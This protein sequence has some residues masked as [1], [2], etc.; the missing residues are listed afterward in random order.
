M[1]EDTFVDIYLRIGDKIYKD[2][3]DEKINESPES[4]DYVIIDS[5]NEDNMDLYNKREY[6]LKDKVVTFDSS[7]FI[8]KILE[9][10]H[11]KKE[12]ILHQFF[13][14]FPRTDIY[15]NNIKISS[16][17][18]FL[19]KVYSYRNYEVTKGIKLDTII[20]MLCNQSSYAFSYEIIYDLYSTSKTHVVSKKTCVKINTNDDNQI[21]MQFHV[22]YNIIDIECDSN[23]NIIDSIN[24]VSYLDIHIDKRNRRG[25]ISTQGLLIWD[26]GGH[27]IF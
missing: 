14:D 13:L 24:M 18:F 23:D 4:Q 15:Y 2:S 22:T 21:F 20:I 9:S 19:E 1:I 12:N 6:M 16:S 3:Y 26:T 5:I 25:N 11:N 27:N 7:V 10:Y 8:K 17:Q